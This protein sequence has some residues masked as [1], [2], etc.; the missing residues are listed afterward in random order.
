MLIFN[1]LILPEGFWI[2]VS[3]TGPLQLTFLFL[4]HAIYKLEWSY[5]V[6]YSSIHEYLHGQ[7]PA[8][9]PNLADVI[10]REQDVSRGQI[11]VHESFGGQITHSQGN[12]L[13]ILKQHLWH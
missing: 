3:Y 7:N 10:V 11:P 5:S 1:C 6:S 4:V 12:L 13:T 2:A 8:C 9:L